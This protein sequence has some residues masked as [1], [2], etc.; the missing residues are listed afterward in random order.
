[1]IFKNLFW[2]IFS[3]E[4]VMPNFAVNLVI[5]W[6][7]FDQF[8]FVK[9][10]NLHF[11]QIKFLSLGYFQSQRYII[12]KPCDFKNFFWKYFQSR[13]SM[14]NFAVNPVIFWPCFDQFTFAKWKMCAFFRLSF[15]T[16]DI[17]NLTDTNL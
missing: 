2:K 16:W 8:T 10:E 11:F 15:S 7:C 4:D 13:M 12:V 3:F 14:P 9:M 17:S 5:F 1:M 6:P